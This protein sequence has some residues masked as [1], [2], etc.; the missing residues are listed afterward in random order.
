MTEGLD[1]ESS[2]RPDILLR[3]VDGSSTTFP[4]ALVQHVG[5]FRT[6]IESDSTCDTISLGHGTRSDFK[7]VHRFIQFLATLST[8]E[9]PE[10]RTYIEFLPHDDATVTAYYE[11]YSAFEPLPAVFLE[12]MSQVANYLTL[13]EYLDI[14]SMLMYF[15]TISAWKIKMVLG[16]ARDAITDPRALCSIRDLFAETR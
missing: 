11:A 16:D 3:F 5:L 15:S 8:D 7:I 1:L 13:A 9:P 14:P 12:N 2:C 6:I 10:L 4:H